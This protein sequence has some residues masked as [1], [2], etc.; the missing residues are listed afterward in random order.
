MTNSAALVHLRLVVLIT[1]GGDPAAQPSLAEALGAAGAGGRDYHGFRFVA[2]IDRYEA[3]GAR[4]DEINANEV[5]GELC[6]FPVAQSIGTRATAR[7]TTHFHTAGPNHTQ[8]GPTSFLQMGRMLALIYRSDSDHAV[9]QLTQQA[10]TLRALGGTSMAGLLPGHD[11][12][13][14]RPE[15]QAAVEALMARVNATPHPDAAAAAAAIAA[16][17]E[18]AAAV[19]GGPEGHAAA[20]PPAASQ[21]RPPPPTPPEAEPLTKRQ[22]SEF[23]GDAA[24]EEEEGEKGEEGEEEG[25]EGEEEEEVVVVGVRQT[26][27]GP[28]Q[29]PVDAEAEAEESSVMDLEGKQSDDSI[30]SESDAESHTA[31]EVQGGVLQGAWSAIKKRCLGEQG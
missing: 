14:F 8:G 24:E 25:E 7:L 21:A 27:P 16:P 4:V 6:V 15:R 10:A 9:Q 3:L 28:L 12:L 23:G 18:E 2:A 11:C 1:R 19:A 31:R 20:A 30:S 5:R 17:T 29:P 22:R 13:L 26:S